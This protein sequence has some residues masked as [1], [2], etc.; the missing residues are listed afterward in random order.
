[1][2]DFMSA[3]LI[4]GSIFLVMM[5]SQLGHREYSWH[6][7]ALPIVSVA[8]FGWVYL[9][10]L[11]TAGNAIW[12]Y[13]VGIVIGGVFAV[14]TTL[15]TTL[16]RD[17]ATRKLFTRTGTAFLVTWLV[18]VALRIGFV[19]SVDNVSSFRQQVGTFMMSHQLVQDSIAPFFVLMA[20]T[21]VL[22]RVVA[23]KIQATRMSRTN[24]TAGALA[25]AAV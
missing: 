5:V 7:I 21:T 20:L 6:K 8:A 19:W 14:F 1:M 13:L 2:S 23:L 11:P 17:S 12:L 3:L 22:G 15:S 10:H 9:R 18:A 4:S 16:E 24:A 25:A